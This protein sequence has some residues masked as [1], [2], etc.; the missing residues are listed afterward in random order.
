MMLYRYERA[1][2]ETTLAGNDTCGFPRED[3]MHLFRDPVSGDIP[4]PGVLGLTVNSIWYWCA[5][6][7]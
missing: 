3:A 7:V 5:D 2:P 4:W 6:Q 1:V